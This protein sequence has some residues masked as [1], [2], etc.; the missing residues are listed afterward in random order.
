MDD[1][2]S[3]SLSSAPPT[4]DEKPLAPIFAKMAKGKKAAPRKKKA[5]V[6]PPTPPSPPR[7][8]R[9]PSPPHED[10]AFS[11]KLAHLGPQDIER[12]VAES[13]PSPQ[14]EE[15][16]C[17]MLAL[18]L[19]RK[20]PVE[21]GHH[22]RAMEEALSTQKHQWPLSWN[23]VNPLA[24]SRTFPDMSPAE[25]LNLLRTLAIW[26]LTSS[27]IV[28]Q[29]IKDS[30]KISRREDDINQPLS[31]QHWGYDGDKRKYYLIEGQEDTS[32]R[33]YRESN[34]LSQHPQWWSVAETIDE[35]NALA[36]K[37]ETKDT[38]QAARRLA[39]KVK[40]AV[41]R[42]EAS[43]EKRRR[44]E[45]RQARKAQFTKPELG[46][47][48]YEGRTRG[49]RIRYTYSDNEDESDATGS[50]RS[51]RHSGHST[52]ADSG[53][54]VT[55]SGRQVRPA[56]TGIYGE[57]L[58]SGQA[59]TPD[60]AASETSRT[61]GRATRNSTRLSPLNEDRKRKSRGY[62]SMDED[63]D[64]D[65]APSSGNEWDGGD[66]DDD[67]EE[68]DVDMADGEDEDDM[69]LDQDAKRS[70]IVKLKVRKPQEPVKTE[71]APVEEK[72]PP[73]A[74]ISRVSV[75]RQDLENL[76]TKDELAPAPPAPEH[77]AAVD[78][79]DFEVPVQKTY[80]AHPPPAPLPA[81]SMPDQQTNGGM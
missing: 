74:D 61:S 69:D 63:S 10:H 39:D 31:V 46:F 14:V 44:R 27:E 33:V 68:D 77:P 4:D 6:T 52:P 36:E 50:R 19:N 21:R 62:N 12:G 38:T 9:S 22:G 23:R 54:V 20:K 40:A 57:S 59:E 15:L 79:M 1:S 47:S 11:S 34:R 76:S 80:H 30:Y 78:S 56:R 60:Y 71:T 26:S 25:R 24:G 3:S 2:D 48:L 7:P 64:E 37:L 17:A 66:D 53:P 29:T 81:A 58:L 18:V 55:A 65:D 70:L 49:K 51:A 5:P 41:P 67:N 28:S 45:Y 16:M 72:P 43:E 13:P 8:K 42:F 35:V 75:A 32:F 73:I